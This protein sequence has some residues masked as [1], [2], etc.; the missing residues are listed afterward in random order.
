MRIMFLLYMTAICI[1]A[2]T[3]GYVVR[4]ETGLACEA[5]R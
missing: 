1:D 3:L 5:P 4:A 2:F